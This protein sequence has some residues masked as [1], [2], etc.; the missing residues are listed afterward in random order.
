VQR[1]QR[2]GASGPA[3]PM[4]SSFLAGRSGHPQ[5][6]KRRL[7]LA[8][9]TFAEGLGRPAERASDWEWLAGLLLEHLALADPKRQRHGGPPTS[10]KHDLVSQSGGEFPELQALMRGPNYLAGLKAESRPVALAV[11]EHYRR[12][13]SRWMPYPAFLGRRRR[14]GLPRLGSCCSVSMPKR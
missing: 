3:W 1:R 7:Q 12:L 8:S 5:R 9:V 14:R 2:T 11:L 13:G 6:G 4:R 10:A